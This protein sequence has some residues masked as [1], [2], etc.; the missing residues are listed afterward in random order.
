MESCERKGQVSAVSPPKRAVMPG[1]R[2]LHVL[3]G[4]ALLGGCHLFAAEPVTLWDPAV[5][6]PKRADIPV[7]ED[8][9]FHVIKPQ[10][11]EHRGGHAERPAGGHGV[12]GPKAEARASGGSVTARAKPATSRMLSGTKA[13]IEKSPSSKSGAA[14][15]NRSR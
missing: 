10:H 12:A 7:L 4:L 1:R 2:S 3:F 9:V 14:S 11:P 15:G 5:P 8:V 6:L 13:T